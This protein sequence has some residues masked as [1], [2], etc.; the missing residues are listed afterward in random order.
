MCTLAEWIITL[1]VLDG[2]LQP[3]CQNGL[4]GVNEPRSQ[5]QFGSHEYENT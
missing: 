1:P 4:T 2:S 5:Q 3:V